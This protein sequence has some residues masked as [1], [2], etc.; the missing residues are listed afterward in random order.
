MKNEILEFYNKA[1]KDD[2]FLK[3]LQDFRNENSNAEAKSVIKNVVL[4]YSKKKGYNF[5]E[6]ELSEIADSNSLNLD[7]LE[8]VAGGFG[9][10]PFAASLFSLFSMILGGN[11]NT[12][13]PVQPG[14]V[15]EQTQGQTNVYYEKIVSND[16]TF[17]VEF[18]D[19]GATIL[20]VISIPENGRVKIPSQSAGRNITSISEKAFEKHKDKLTEVTFDGGCELKTIKKRNVQ[21]MF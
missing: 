20:D 19:D 4:P 12:T 5:S 2:E 10:L 16:C 7:D 9:L 3:N 17:L 18:T 13:Q 21:R 15:Q 8:Q 6:S 14:T 11:N 1:A